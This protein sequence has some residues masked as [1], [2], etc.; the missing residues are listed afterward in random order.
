MVQSYS[1]LTI[2]IKTLILLKKNYQYHTQDMFNML[3]KTQV[4]TKLDLEA[5]HH[6]IEIHPDDQHR[7]GFITQDGCFQWKVMPFGLKI[8]LLLF[9]E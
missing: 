7:T 1:G 8:Q 6:Q 2:G 9:R 3:C 5:A 4:F